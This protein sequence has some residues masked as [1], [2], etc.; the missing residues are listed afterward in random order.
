MSDELTPERIAE[1]RERIGTELY[2]DGCSYYYGTKPDD[3]RALLDAIESRDAEIAD[4]VE[5][6]TTRHADM[7]GGP[8]FWNKWRARSDAANPTSLLRAVFNARVRQWKSHNQ[9]LESEQWMRNTDKQL[10]E[11]DAEI[12]RLKRECAMGKTMSDNRQRVLRAIA[13][14]AYGSIDP[15][16]HVTGAPEL[17]ELLHEALD[18][19]DAER[20]LLR[21]YIQHVA[22]S[23]GRLFL[24]GRVWKWS[25][26]ELTEEEVK[27]MRQ[28][29][30]PDYD[31][32]RHDKGTS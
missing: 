26:C 23:V 6:A 11:R 1:L 32:A 28:L 18:M 14:D 21:R 22:N 30:S 29:S 7:D 20:D 5:I 13:D 17:G 25:D 9:A 16:E 19:V 8:G 15:Y 24:R 2:A 12:E 27:Y 31:W 10:A 3:V 4:A